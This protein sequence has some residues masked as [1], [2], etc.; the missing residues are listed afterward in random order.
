M[1]GGPLRV[2]AVP[3]TFTLK[4]SLAKFA[5]AAWVSSKST[6][7]VLPFALA[8]LY[9]GAVVSDGVESVMESCTIWLSAHVKPGL[10]HSARSV[11]GNGSG[12][13]SFEGGDV[14]VFDAE[15]H[16]YQVYRQAGVPV[17]FGVAAFA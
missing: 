14:A 6:T 11:T 15:P 2:A 9:V 16:S 13:G 5:A 1:G 7:S 8:E 17:F 10:V 4:A 12:V 3:P